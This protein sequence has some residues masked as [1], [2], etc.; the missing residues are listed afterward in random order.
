MKGRGGWYGDSIPWIPYQYPLH[1]RYQPLY[2]LYIYTLIEWI[3]VQT[4]GPV[5][6]PTPFYTLLNTR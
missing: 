2:P 1:C 4:P 6:P 3:V 5:G